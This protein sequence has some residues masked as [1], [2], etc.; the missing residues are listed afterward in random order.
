MA[1]AAQS[2]SQSQPPSRW[3]WEFLK[4][5]LAPYPG[6]AALVARMTLAATLVMIVCMTFRIPYA[7]QGAIYV[8]MISRE[9]PRATLRSAALIAMVTAIGAAYLLISVRF[10][11]SVPEVHFL[12]VIIS[13][14]LA[15]YAISALTNYTAAVVFAIM[16]SVGIPLWDRH[17]PADTNVDDTLWLCLAVLVGVAITGAVELV[18]ARLRPGNEVVSPITE[19]LDAVETLFTC[20]AEDR[21][22]DP[23]TEKRILRLGMLG[24]SLLRRTLRRSNYSAQYSVEISGVAVLVGRLVDLAATLTHLRFEL[25]VSDQRRFRNLAS[26]IAIIRDD[27]DEPAS[28]RLQSSLIT[29]DSRRVS[30]RY[31]ERWS[32]QLVLSPRRLRIL[33]RSKKT[34][35]RPKMHD[36]QSSSPSAR[37][38]TPSTCS[39]RSKVAWLRPSVT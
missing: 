6:R 10:V 35:H 39:L 9:S 26:M 25:S 18:F 29:M 1:S 3:L 31:L 36:K 23:H 16:T 32:T 33:D 27:L 15:F 14:F 12:W 19:R 11:I 24:T 38:P 21:A 7:F 5:E 28:T 30:F 8:L 13:L 20:Y 22:V 37:S 2:L 17:V 4:E 34:C